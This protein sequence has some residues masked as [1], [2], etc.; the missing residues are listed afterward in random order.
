MIK[1]RKEKV[2]HLSNR[3]TES[4]ASFDSTLICDSNARNSFSYRIQ[5]TLFALYQIQSINKLWWRLTWL[6]STLSISVHIS[7]MHP[8]AVRLKIN[9]SIKTFISKSCKSF[10][11]LVWLLTNEIA[12]QIVV[13]FVLVYSAQNARALRI[14]NPISGSSDINCP[15]GAKWKFI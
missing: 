6:H 14:K 12:R 13:V 9:T 10:N 1:R 7:R 11:A 5:S 2:H 15:K 4:W 8:D 3:V